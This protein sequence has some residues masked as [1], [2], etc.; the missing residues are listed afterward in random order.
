MNKVKSMKLFVL[1]KKQKEKYK[2]VKIF[3]V[4]T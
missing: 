1:N 4:N 3:L 2:C